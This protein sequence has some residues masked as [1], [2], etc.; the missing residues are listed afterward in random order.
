MALP[1]QLDSRSHV[2][3]TGCVGQLPELVHPL[4]KYPQLV[5]GLVQIHAD[6]LQH[7]YEPLF[8]EV[9]RIGILGTSPFGHSRKFTKKVVIDTAIE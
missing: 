5:R 3:V 7:Y 8:T 9:P 1:Q 2:V 6:L 4:R